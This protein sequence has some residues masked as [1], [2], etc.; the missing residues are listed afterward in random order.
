MAEHKIQPKLM[1]LFIDT[2]GVG[3]T[4]DTVV[5]GK[6]IGVEESWEE[7]D[8]SSQCGED[9]YIGNATQTLSFS[10]QH[11][12]DADTG[13]ISGTGLRTAARTKVPMKFKLAVETPVTGD[14][15]ET[16]D[17]VI[18]SI[19]SSYSDTEVGTFDVSFKVKGVS[20]IVVT[21]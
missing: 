6:T 7:I 5:C 12:E 16:G 21:A 17:C 19:S 20:T 9:V 8:A 10:G 2:T 4:F 14:T 11:L 3:T 15:V 18:T 13:K 1:Y